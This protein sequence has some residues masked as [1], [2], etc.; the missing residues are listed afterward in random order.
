MEWTVEQVG[1]WYLARNRFTGHT[2]CAFM[3]DFGS[4]REIGIPELYHFLIIDH[5]D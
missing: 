4:L 2:L 1:F 5:Q 3:D